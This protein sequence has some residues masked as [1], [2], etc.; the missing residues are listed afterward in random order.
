MR[1]EPFHAISGD[2]WTPFYETHPPKRPPSLR[3]RLEAEIERLIE[4]LD[5][6][7]GDTDFE[8]GADREPRE[9]DWAQPTTAASRNRLAR[10]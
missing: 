7:D 1:I 10:G 2:E 9:H 4:M 8:E 5:N 6:L 3:D